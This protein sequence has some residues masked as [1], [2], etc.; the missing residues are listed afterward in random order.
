MMSYRLRSGELVTAKTPDW[1][2]QYAN[3]T[4]AEKAAAKIPGACVIHRGRPFYVRLMERPETPVETVSTETAY[5]RTVHYPFA[6][7]VF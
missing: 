4:Q 7:K 1:P 2:I 3:R 6:L 5:G